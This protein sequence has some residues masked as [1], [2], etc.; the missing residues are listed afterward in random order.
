[1]KKFITIFTFII[2]F[3]FTDTTHSYNSLDC[4]ELYDTCIGNNPYDED[5]Q[6]FYYY[7][8]LNGC[9]SS[10]NFCFEFQEN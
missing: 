7:G 8:Y 6:F 9:S 5:Y 3:S 10:R 2:F 4:E 1:M